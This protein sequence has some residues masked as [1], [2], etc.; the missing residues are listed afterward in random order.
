MD[1][2]A[3]EEVPPP[4]TTDR[5]ARRLGMS[6]SIFEG[7][8]AQAQTSCCGL[9]AGGPNAVTIGFAF[10]LGAKDPE[11]GLLAALPVYGNLLQYVAA[12]L[13]PRLAKR[14]PLVAI[15]STVARVAYLPMGLLPLLV[16]RKDLVLA[17]FLALWFVTNALISLSGNLWTTWMADLVPPRVRGRYFS[18][19]TRATT[20][21]AVVVPLALSK[22]LDLWF[23]G[24]PSPDEGGGS[25]FELQAQGFAL[26]FG[27]AAIFGVVSGVLLLRQP[28]L[29][30][31]TSA[32][33]PLD[34]AFFLGPIRDRAF[35]PLLAFV[36]VFGAANGL[37]NPFWIPFQL[38]DLGLGYRYVNGWFV[39]L[40]GATMA[41]SL[42][43]WGR[44]SDRVGNRPVIALSL[45]LGCTHPYYYVFATKARWW[46]MFGDAASSGI[47]WAGFN[48]ALFNLVLALAPRASRELYVATQAVVIGTAQATASVL[49]GWLAARLPAALALVGQSLC[50]RQQI[51]L[52]TAIARLACLGFFLGAVHEPRSKP[53]RTFVIA[54]HG[55]VKARIETIKMIAQDD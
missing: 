27:A 34:A 20:I 24:V 50:P 7:M 5:A 48:L 36:A 38:Q 28:E 19:R 8:S 49:A 10:L 15:T 54:A 52:V 3:R 43:L 17:T 40:Q 53:I 32:A 51:F 12:A 23:G 39:A 29:P 21:V 30:R 6:L 25:R 46:L 45:A 11:L 4:L 33:P 35:W 1:V 55:Y 47:A 16:A 2:S 13:G 18:I 26:A 37:A 22:V 9:G 42:P 31:D 41:L 14:R 44:L